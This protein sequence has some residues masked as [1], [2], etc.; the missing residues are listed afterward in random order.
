MTKALALTSSLFVIG[1]LCGC[2]SPPLTSKG[3]T[4]P[5]ITPDWSFVVDEFDDQGIHVIAGG[6][7]GYAT[8]RINRNGDVQWLSEFSGEV[9]G[10]FGSFSQSRYP[11]V[12]VDNEESWI[13]TNISYE[14]STMLSED[15][16]VVIRFDSNGEQIDSVTP[17]PESEV[18]LRGAKPSRDGGAYLVGQLLGEPTLPLIGKVDSQAELNWVADLSEEQD[19]FSPR[20]VV[21]A[22]DG[23]LLITGN[24]VGG[25]SSAPLLKISTSGEVE[26]WR[27]YDVGEIGWPSAI[28]AMP[29]G[30][31]VLGAWDRIGPVV[32]RTSPSGLPP[33]NWSTAYESLTQAPWVEET[34]QW[35]ARSGTAPR[36]S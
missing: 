3:W 11:G 28:D 9:P 24:Y 8:I 18:R 35:Q 17:F 15:S 2:P 14:A 30:G 5:A 7:N 33:L 22:S 36:R 16:V 21:E 6:A 31:A 25:G 19:D 4:Y 32:F 29:D 12:L 1:I 26:F 13:I 10:G 23:A 20:D 34:S 27:F